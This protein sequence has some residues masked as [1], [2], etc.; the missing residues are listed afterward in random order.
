MLAQAPFYSLNFEETVQSFSLFFDCFG[1]LFW[2]VQ[3]LN[4]NGDFAIKS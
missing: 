2:L 1:A 4:K 3:S